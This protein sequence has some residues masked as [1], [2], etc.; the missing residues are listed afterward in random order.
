MAKDGPKSLGRLRPKVS[1]T[2][3]PSE[4]SVTSSISLLWKIRKRS[5]SAVYSSHPTT[6]LCA[7]FLRPKIF[8]EAPLDAYR[9]FPIRKPLLHTRQI[10]RDENAPLHFGADEHVH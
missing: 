2:G 9:L 1:R 3:A 4:K 6:V 8:A 7:G 10:A 5:G